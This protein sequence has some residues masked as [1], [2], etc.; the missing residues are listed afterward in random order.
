[1]DDGDLEQMVVLWSFVE[2]A[3]GGVPDSMRISAIT[4]AC[5]PAPIRYMIRDVDVV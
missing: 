2:K 1:L 3:V 5:P 4:L